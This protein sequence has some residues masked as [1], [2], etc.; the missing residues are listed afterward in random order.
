M[1]FITKLFVVKTKQFYCEF[2]SNGVTAWTVIQRRGPYGSTQRYLFNQDY[3]HYRGGFGN[4]A[5][6]YWI[7]LNFIHQVT[8]SQKINLMVTMEKFNEETAFVII[9]GFRLNDESNNYSFDYDDIFTMNEKFW[10]HIWSS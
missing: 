2:R 4:P 1:E 8:T 6:E 7:G 3:Q 10:Y 5:E 9:R